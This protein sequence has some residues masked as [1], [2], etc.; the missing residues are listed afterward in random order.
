M[1][2]ENSQVIDIEFDGNFGILNWRYLPY[3]RPIFEAYVREYHHNIW[4]KIWYVYVPP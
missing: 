2:M 4:P 3:I 1:A